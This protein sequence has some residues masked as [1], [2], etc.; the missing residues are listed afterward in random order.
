MN[1]PL[2]RS[3]EAATLVAEVTGSVLLPGDAAYEAETAAFNMT[4]AHRP[5]VVIA[6]ATAAD[7]RV[8]VRFAAAHGLPA[9]VLSTGHQPLTPADGAVLITM[10]EM[11]TVTVDPAARV[12]RVE[13]G[14]RWGDVVAA[15][16][17]HGLAPLNG[18]TPV[19]GVAG[20]VLGGGHSPMLGRTYGWAADHVHA[21]DLVTPDGRL[22]R[23]T[24]ETEPD[25]FWAVRGGKSNFGAVTALEFA[26]FPVAS[27]YAGGLFFDGEHT[28]AVVHAWRRT[29]IDAP[30]ELNTSLALL[31]LP[32]LPSVPE[33]LRGRLVVHVR[34][35]HAGDAAEGARLLA[36]LRAAAP[37]IMDTVEVLPYAR[38]A[39][40]HQDPT[41]PMAYDERSTL[42]TE[43]TAEAVEVI[44]RHAGPA[45][46]FAGMFLELRHLGGAL[47]REPEQPNAVC[48]RDA[49]YTLVGAAVGAPE[50][51]RAPIAQLDALITDLDKWQ[52]GHKFL[53]FMTAADET[54]EAYTPETYARLRAI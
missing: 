30:D 15:A 38:Y 8:A 54:E 16:V 18:S 13:A 3:E 45:S 14:A 23:V 7:V 48:A 6:A 29:T 35:S 9:A 43:L 22:R 26:L 5:A 49:L 17:P 37:V 4:V 34:V 10:R 40:V 44:V 36:P 51:T 12:A 46:G 31:R 32:A 42:L 1:V 39:E 28:A 24:A 25:L 47:A 53:N 27:T 11:N 50:Q 41:E 20:Y 2:F 21:L 19:V 52:T 33:P